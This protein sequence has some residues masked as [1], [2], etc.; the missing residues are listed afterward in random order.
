[1]LQLELG[2]EPDRP[3]TQQTPENALN[4]P[5]DPKLKRGARERWRAVLELPTSDLG[6]PGARGE[7]RR[8]HADS[9]L[10][11]AQEYCRENTTIDGGLPPAANKP[12]PQRGRLL[13]LLR[14]LD[15]TTATSCIFFLF[16]AQPLRGV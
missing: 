5:P 6:A 1:M 16:A 9:T 12:K 14:G 13:S 11:L 4:A 10:G 15:R 8:P 3:Y 2:T 7:L